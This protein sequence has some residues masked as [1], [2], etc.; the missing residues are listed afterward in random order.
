MD[1]WQK[2]PTLAEERKLRK[3]DEVRGESEGDFKGVKW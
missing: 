2:R 3:V 1:G